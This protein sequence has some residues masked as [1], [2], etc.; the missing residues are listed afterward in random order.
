MGASAALRWEKQA[1]QTC[2]GRPRTNK[3][4][5]R[6]IG[7]KRY[8]SMNYPRPAVYSNNYSCCNESALI[9][10][11]WLKSV[12]PASSCFIKERQTSAHIRDVT[13]VQINTDV[14]F[15]VCWG[16]VL[17]SHFASASTARLT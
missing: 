17:W 15:H 3:M 2:T 11:L 8:L 14:W 6:L 7:V 9:V 16:R 10:I 13:Y 12:P 5:I 1:E 4:G